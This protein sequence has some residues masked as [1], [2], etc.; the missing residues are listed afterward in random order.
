[1]EVG[2][3][4]G[5]SDNIEYCVF[6]HDGN[7]EPF[8]NI[9][10]NNKV[11]YKDNF[12]IIFVGLQNDEYYDISMDILNKNIRI[13]S[14]ELIILKFIYKLRGVKRGEK[15]ML[16]LDNNTFTIVKQE[17]SRAIKSL[18]LLLDNYI[19]DDGPVDIS[20]CDIE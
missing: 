12:A 2:V 7:K 1:M 13:L 5:V 20:T 9:L 6:F 10:L 11:D 8:Y 16:I 19:M 18:M 15:N 4:L 17:P 14:N 3:F